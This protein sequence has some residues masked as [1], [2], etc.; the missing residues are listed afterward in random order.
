[1]TFGESR[2][3][4]AVTWTQYLGVPLQS[5]WQWLRWSA[6]AAENNTREFWV[7]KKRQINF[8]EANCQL[9]RVYRFE[10]SPYDVQTSITGP[11]VMAPSTFFCACIW[12]QIEIEQ[13]GGKRR[14]CHKSSSKTHWR[15]ALHQGPRNASDERDRVVLNTLSKTR[16]W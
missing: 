5:L 12:N 7:A 6:P 2:G 14:N 4:A 3:F 16:D 13:P 15:N 8:T 10:C 9:A 11:E 1:M